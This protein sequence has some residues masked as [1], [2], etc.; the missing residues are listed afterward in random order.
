VL[1]VVAGGAGFIGASLVERLQ[2]EGDEVVI[3]DDLSHGNL[4]NL[5]EA[6]GRGRVR[7]HRIDIGAGGLGTLAG[8]FEADAWVHLAM[9][10]DP[11]R[12]WS[13]PSA[14]ARSLL[15]G[16]VEML[17]V[18]AGSGARVVIAS[19]GA[20]LFPSQLTGVTRADDRPAPQ[21]PLGAGRLACE[22]YAASYA[23]RGLDV[24]V[25]ALGTIYG[26]RQDPLGAGLVASAAWSMLQG[27]PPRIDGD[28]RQERDWLY[29]DDAVD[30]LA[31][32]VRSDAGGRLLVGTGTATP[33]VDVVERLG[34]QTGWSGEPEWAPARPADPRRSALDPAQAGK[35]LGWHPWTELDEGLRLTIAWL[36]G[37]L[38]AKPRYTGR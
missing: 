11:V 22:A 2:A 37:K 8:R 13:A 27:E 20:Y 38:P 28:G 4:A 32:A 18:A 9:A 30:A 35:L 29:V 3:L 23:A 10:S 21:H 34:S 17:E 12:V 31:R 16:T 36:R 25:L 5:T 15:A 14:D 33:V 24:A 19:S 26:P 6:R 7:F 1:V